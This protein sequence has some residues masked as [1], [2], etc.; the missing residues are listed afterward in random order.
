MNILAVTSA[1]RAGRGIGLLTDLLGD[2]VGTPLTGI[3]TIEQAMAA[4]RETPREPEPAIAPE[5]AT[6]LVHAML[7]RQ[8]RAVLDEPVPMLDG[9]TPRAAARTKAGRDRL[10]AWIK[11]FEN[12]SGRQFDPADP[13][14]AYDFT[15]MWKKL[16]VE[17]LRR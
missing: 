15:W 3:E 14:A 9:A 6:P 8:Y 16:F 4:R 5:I 1:E 2:L 12:S 17:N 11:H 10:A 13:M 7:D